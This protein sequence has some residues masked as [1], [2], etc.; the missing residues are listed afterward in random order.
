MTE[1][2]ALA[3][4]PD[5]QW[6]ALR[7]GRE[8]TLVHHGGEPVG[9]VGKIELDGDDVELALVGPP[10]ALA[11]VSRQGGG[12]RL[13]LHQPP[14][15]EAV[16]RLDLELPARI[17]AITGPRLVMV[18]PTGNKVTVVRAAGRALASQT[19]DVGGPVE[20]AV[21]LDKHQVLL[22]LAKKL[23]VWDA[24]SGRPMLRMN[25]QLPPPPRLVGAA[26]GHLWATRPGSD[27]AYVYRL[28]DG[29]PF[30]HYIG[31]PIADVCCHP[32][33]PVIV[34]ATARGL[35][36]LH[37]FAHSLAVVDD[38]PWTP[39]SAL[40][41]LVA[42]DDVTLIGLGDG[43]PWHVAI[44]GGPAAAESTATDPAL[45]GA[46]RTARTGAAPTT[47]LAARGS[48]ATPWREQLA[49]YA[50]ELTRG[51]DSELPVV[52]VDCEFGELAHRLKL[53][54]AARRALIALY[55]LYLIGEPELAVA[56]VAHAIGDWAEP[57]GRGELAAH[58]MLNR[59]A[60]KVALRTAV[61]DLL[62]G[63]P[64]R[65]IHVVGDGV[66]TR[67]AGTHQVF[68]DGKPDGELAR[69]LVVRL[70]R[71]AIVD[72][73]LPRALLEAHL[74]GLTA[75]AM[76]PPT[77]RPSPWP[78]DGALVIVVQSGGGWCADLPGL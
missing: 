38:A 13:Q 19:F 62:D 9:V 57:L 20:F 60:G 70:G 24:V 25:L 6:V 39:G 46:E 51:G 73:K 63:A 42:G 58:A 47:E 3:T 40:A 18:A 44:G 8:L 28:S 55:A 61:S 64:P 54:S 41:Q 74:R 16:A 15:L 23:E 31:A 50:S 21:G 29:R 45:A 72:G 36:R 4:S 17:A 66:P 35:V 26:S 69:E 77:A 27:E 48:G 32:A 11:V 43:E 49:S 7:R 56:R 10:T 1:A 2:R 68:R 53:G 75:V 12:T 33:S 71:I 76:E 37:C 59:R 52:A 22:G 65:A 30:R 14:Y 5:G 78:R 67:R 34:F